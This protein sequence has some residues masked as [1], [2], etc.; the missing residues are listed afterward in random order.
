LRSGVTNEL[1]KLSGNSPE[2]RERFMIWE[3]I[4]AKTLEQDFR[5]EVGIGSRSH[6][7]FGKE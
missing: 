2:E 3:I 5:R 7:L 6:C 4:G 1:L